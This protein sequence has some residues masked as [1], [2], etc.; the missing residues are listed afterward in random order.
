MKI[1]ATL[2]LTIAC[3]QLLSQTQVF[4]TSR[5]ELK[6]TPV[7]HAT[8]VMEFGEEVIYVDPTGGAKPFE[9]FKA[10]TMI[11][12]TDIHGDHLSIE[13]LKELN[14]KRATI[15]AP[16]AVSDELTAKSCGGALT[17][18]PNTA[19]IDHHGIHIDAIPMYN[20]PESADS[21][22]PKGRGSGYVLN[23]GDKRIYISGDTEDIPEMRA[24]KNIDIAFV[25]MNLP[26]TMDIMQAA[27]A[28]S[29]FKPTIVFPYHY[30][31]T[32]GFSDVKDFKN[33]VEDQNPEIEVRLLN[34]YP[35]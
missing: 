22:H 34:W 15:F 29:E 18:M 17:I 35:N 23:I 3:L 9:K 24:L 7:S 13:T 8:L 21:F 14:L 20:L 30:R 31:G 4:E 25:C 2:F 19:K 6:I 33:K 12:I 16:M 26:Y 28:V 27:S 11:L 5:G 32:E 1:A 10:P